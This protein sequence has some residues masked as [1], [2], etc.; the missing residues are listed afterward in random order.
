MHTVTAW[1]IWQAHRVHRGRL[2]ERLQSE[3]S[4]SAQ[5]QPHIE[6]KAD[7]VIYGRGLRDT[8]AMA[9]PRPRPEVPLLLPAAEPPVRPL[10]A[11]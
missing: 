2:E 7:R 4:A 5:P 1:C 8:L 6:E 10:P 3:P 11:P 9:P